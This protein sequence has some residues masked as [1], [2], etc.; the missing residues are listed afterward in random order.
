MKEDEEMSKHLK[1]SVFKALVLL[2]VGL[3]IAA[4]SGCCPGGAGCDWY[5]SDHEKQ[6]QPKQE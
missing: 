4:I 3:F 6:E 1:S 2:M 5:S